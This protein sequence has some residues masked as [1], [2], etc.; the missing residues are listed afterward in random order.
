MVTLDPLREAGGLIAGHAGAAMGAMVLGAAQLA[1]PKGTGLH[2]GAGYGFMLL[3]AG[4]AISSFWIHGFRLVGPFSP[5]HLLSVFVLYS[6][7]EALRDARRGNIARHRRRMIQL[8]I[9]AMVVTGL[10]TLWPGR[11]MHKVLFGG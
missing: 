5:I 6:L 3:M 11:V 10:F 4:V 7:W 1:L 8:Y 9:Y 2:R